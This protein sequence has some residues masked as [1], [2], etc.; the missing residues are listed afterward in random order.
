VFLN[1]FTYLLKLYVLHQA[2]IAVQRPL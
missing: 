2:M 1:L